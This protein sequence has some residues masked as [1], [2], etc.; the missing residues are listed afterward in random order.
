MERASFEV[1]RFPSRFASAFLS[2]AECP[3]VFSSLGGNISK[4]LQ[5][6]SA[7][8]GQKRIQ[9]HVT[10]VTDNYIH[11][12]LYKNSADLVTTYF[13]HRQNNYYCPLLLFF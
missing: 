4:Q 3:E 8:F 10:A 2:S 5:N 1:Q 7:S 11:N 9:C 6:Y 12:V 13:Q